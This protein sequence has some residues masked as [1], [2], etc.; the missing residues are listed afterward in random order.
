[1]AETAEVLPVGALPL[2]L[3]I[4]RRHLQLQQVLQVKLRL[5]LISDSCCPPSTFDTVRG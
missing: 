5:V 1:M 2:H 4:V 3:H